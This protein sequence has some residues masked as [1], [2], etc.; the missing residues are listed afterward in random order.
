MTLRGGEDRAPTNEE[1]AA[2]L[3]ES[4]RWLFLHGM[5][6]EVERAKVLQRIKKVHGPPPL[7][8]TS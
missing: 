1:I 4:A 5:L 3:R 8:R 2:Q 7:G 6:T